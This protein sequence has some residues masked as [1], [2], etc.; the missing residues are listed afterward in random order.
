M[1][2]KYS[3]CHPDK[4]EIEYKNQLISKEEVLEIAKNYPWTEKLDFSD[5]LDQNKVYFNPS[6]DF[7]CTNNGQSFALTA[8]YD[9][10]KNLE[11]SLWYNRPKKVKSF[12]GLFGESEK[13]I[14]D[15][16]WSL[17]LDESLKFLTYF[18]EG[19]YDAIEDLYKK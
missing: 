17:N 11:F 16:Y 15:D 9:K 7:S 12:F 6:L 18:V 14:V 1:T 4:P 10:Q 8:I 3:I 19:K 13:M 5:T 2:F